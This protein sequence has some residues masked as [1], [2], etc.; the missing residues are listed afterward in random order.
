MPGVISLRWHS[1][2]IENSLHVF[3]KLFLSRYSYYKVLKRRKGLYITY[4][5]QVLNQKIANH[6]NTICPA[7]FDLVNSVQHPSHRLQFDPTH[8]TFLLGSQ[9]G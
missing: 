7:L 4:Y 2:L 5:E 8:T 6:S 1:K 9:L 3:P